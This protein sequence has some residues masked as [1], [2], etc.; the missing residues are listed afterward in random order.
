MASFGDQ[1]EL[2]RRAA[3]LKLRASHV[4]EDEE[5]E[6]ED[7]LAPYYAEARAGGLVVNERERRQRLAAALL[8]WYLGTRKPRRR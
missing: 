3:E 4:D 5:A 2:A 8:A 7:E 6:E 1:L